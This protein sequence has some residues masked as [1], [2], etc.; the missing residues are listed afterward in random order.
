MQNLFGALLFENSRK[1][2]RLNRNQIFPWFFHLVLYF[3]FMN[4]GEKNL[5]NVNLPKKTQNFGL[6]D[7]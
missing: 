3:V 4:E 7:K 2:M 5:L 6:D 1:I